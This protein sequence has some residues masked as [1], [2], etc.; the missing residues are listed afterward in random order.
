MVYHFR[1]HIRTTNFKK[2]FLVGPAQIPDALNGAGAAASDPVC[3][4]KSKLDYPAAREQIFFFLPG[5]PSP[6]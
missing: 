2:A 4:D 1:T 6:G 5:G 3:L